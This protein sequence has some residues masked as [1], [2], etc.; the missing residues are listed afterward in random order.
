LSTR[1]YSNRLSAE[2]LRR[3]YEIASPRVQRYLNA[4]VEHVLT[5]IHPNHNVL[6]LGCGYGRVLTSLASKAHRVVGIDTSLVSLQFGCELL[7]RST[8]IHLLQMD[9][10]QL[11]FAD[12]AFD[13]VICIQNGISAFHVDQHTLIE[14]S[15][16][17]TRRGGCI[18]FS[19]YAETFWDERLNWFRAQAIAGLLGEIDEEKTGDGTIVC[20]DGFT[21]TTVSPERF[22]ALTSGIS[23]EIQINE[24]DESSVFCEI[25][26]L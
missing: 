12:Q 11:A 4:E 25:R 19:S 18:L 3:V 7:S 23:A 14:A 9:A 22:R 13:V 20:K 21:A 2:R 5:Y 10:V 26:A 16:R 1:Y 15:I 8:N 17:V 6:E 24:A